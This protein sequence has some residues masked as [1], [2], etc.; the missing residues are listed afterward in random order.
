MPLNR[1]CNHGPHESDD[2]AILPSLVTALYIVDFRKFPSLRKSGE[3]VALG[4]KGIPETLTNGDGEA[5]ID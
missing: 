5:P 4:A 2:N 1:L 3:V